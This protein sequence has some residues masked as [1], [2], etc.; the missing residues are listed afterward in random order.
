MFIPGALN[1]ELNAELA[2]YGPDNVVVTGIKSALGARADETLS[3]EAYPVLAYL[4]IP[5]DELFRSFFLTP[6]RFIVFEMA[7]TGESLCVVLPLSRVARTSEVRTSEIS[8]LT[9]ELDADIVRSSVVSDSIEVTTQPA[10]GEQALPGSR[11]GRIVSSI[12][13]RPASYEIAEAVGTEAA[14]ALGE[15]ARRLRA[16]LES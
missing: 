8:V 7:A 10:E 13:Q 9:I 6:K 11:S 1:A 3:A 15:F 14:A 4:L 2:I 16:A 5:A 12:E